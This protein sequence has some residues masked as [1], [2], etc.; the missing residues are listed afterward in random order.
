MTA[1]LYLLTDGGNTKIGITTDFEK[2]IS[3]Y[4]THNANIEVV[5]D[6]LCESIEEAKRVETA[7][8]Q[9]FKQDLAG[10]SKEWF[11]VI[12][13]I[14]DRYINVLL[15]KPVVH[16]VLPSMHGV[17]LTDNAQELKEKILSLIQIPKKSHKQQD[18]QTTL[19]EQF[20]ELFANKFHL[21]IPKHKL[22]I[23]KILIRDNSCVDTQHC[24]DP[25]QSAGVRQAIRN[26]FVRFPHNDHVSLYFH[27]G[28]L[29]SGY[30]VAFCSALVS[31]PYLPTI[32]DP[33]SIDEMRDAAEMCGWHVTI[34][35]DWS[36]YYPN[37]TGLI[38]YQPKTAISDKLRL[39]DRSFRKW[40]IERKALLELEKF[41]GRDTL[42]K[43][44]FDTVH[45]N[46]FPLDVQSFVDLYQR[47]LNPFLE[48]YEDEENPFWLKD[49][50]LFLFDKWKKETGSEQS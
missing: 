35:H 18:E 31:M 46:T 42:Q 4:H 26:N 32:G 9:I 22:P 48:L 16:T 44:I 50:Y 8:K 33:K 20:S 6:Y 29:G 36:W 13:A 21:G 23:D 34:H 10:K 12:P 11:T 37:Q 24:N 15:E 30:Y 14:V 45:D 17:N 25:Q 2:R 5:K 27:L 7:I 41:D 38:L 1:H 28:K 47:Y 49:A 40:V 43:V 3:T 19:N 39:W